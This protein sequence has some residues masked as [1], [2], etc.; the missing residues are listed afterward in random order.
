MESCGAT[1]YRTFPVRITGQDG[2][3]VTGYRGLIAI[4]GLADDVR[5]LDHGEQ[6][7]AFIGSDRLMDALV[8]AGITDIDAVP[9]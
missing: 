3:V 7:F 6:V 2:S 9:Q 8:L 5:T 1:G 4:G